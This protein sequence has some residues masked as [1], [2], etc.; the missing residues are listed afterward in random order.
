MLWR[1][2]AQVAV[3]WL[4]LILSPVALVRQVRRWWW[5]RRNG[6]WATVGIMLEAGDPP[7]VCRE[8]MILDNCRVQ[9]HLRIT[10]D[11][12]AIVEAVAVG[13]MVEIPMAVPYRAVRGQRI[14]VTG[15]G[16]GWLSGLVR[17][18]SAAEQRR[19]ARA[20]A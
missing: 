6:T 9:G 20:A 19:R 13:A 3:W 17:V 5:R 16:S 8:D 11:G 2:L 1:L 12:V 14:T 10:V 15:R 4:R 18:P 7:L